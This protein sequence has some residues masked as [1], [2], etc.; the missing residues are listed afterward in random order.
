[1][2]IGISCV[3]STNSSTAS[4]ASSSIAGTLAIAA[5]RGGAAV[6]TRIG[7]IDLLARGHGLNGAHTGEPH[8]GAGSS[9]ARPLLA[10]SAPSDRARHFFRER[11][12]A[13]LVT[14]GRVCYNCMVAV[15]KTTCLLSFL[16]EALTCLNWNQIRTHRIIPFPRTKL[17]PICDDDGATPRVHR[18]T[19]SAKGFPRG[20]GCAR[21]RTT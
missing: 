6:A 14:A 19:S 7:S 13:P 8:C 16:T 12:H 10:S 17:S 9:R 3:T 11:T 1:M 2:P 4:P 5:R 20:T 15:H 18:R 21:T